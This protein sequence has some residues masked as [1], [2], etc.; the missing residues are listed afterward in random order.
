MIEAPVLSD[1][2]QLLQIFL[3]QKMKMEW[4]VQCVSMC[5][6]SGA[7]WRVELLCLPLSQCHLGP[8]LQHLPGLDL[9]GLMQ[10]GYSNDT[11]HHTLHKTKVNP[12]HKKAIGEH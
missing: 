2:T 3:C 10:G 11:L 5:V 8:Q 12:R 6:S 7:P 9:L 1:K 4:L